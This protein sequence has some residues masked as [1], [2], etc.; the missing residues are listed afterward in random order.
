MM[1]SKFSVGEV[2]ILYSADFPEYNGEY[3]VVG[4]TRHGSVYRGEIVNATDKT[5]YYYDLGF[6][7]PYFRNFSVWNEE[8]LRKR[9]QKGDMSFKE[10][11]KDLKTNIQERA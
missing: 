2:V 7:T 5:A 6:N 4:V 1:K 11:V 8:C 3:S 9:H 10:L